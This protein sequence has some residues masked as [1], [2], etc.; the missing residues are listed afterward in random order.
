MIATLFISHYVYDDEKSFQRFVPKEQK[1]DYNINMKLKIDTINETAKEVSEDIDKLI[2]NYSGYE[3]QT[4]SLD[5]YLKA[6][7]QFI[8]TLKNDENFNYLS[9][10]KLVYDKDEQLEKKIY[11]PIPVKIYNSKNQELYLGNLIEYYKINCDFPCIIEIDLDNCSD[12]G[13]EQFN[14]WIR[15][16]RKLL[17]IP[18]M[19]MPM[20]EKIKRLPRKEFKFETINNYGTVTTGF[21]QNCKLIEKLAI[22]KYALYVEKI[23]FVANK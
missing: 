20:Q 17:S 7:K 11:S 10:I 23:I 21:F 5:N 14:T 15:L 9:E 16:T 18:N 1:K 4:E 12:L 2:W 22:N 3:V 19:V 13:Q 8:E 6:D